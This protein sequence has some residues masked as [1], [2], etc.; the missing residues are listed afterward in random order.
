MLSGT[1][2]PADPFFVTLSTLNVSDSGAALASGTCIH[3]YAFFLFD[4][5]LIFP[6][7]C[8]YTCIRLYLL[9]SH[10][11]FFIINLFYFLVYRYR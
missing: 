3:S 5:F 7:Y 11:Y 8:I 1:V 10:T 2:L 6:P 4:Q 9:P